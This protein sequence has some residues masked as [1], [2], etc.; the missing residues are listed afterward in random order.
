MSAFHGVF[1]YLVSPIDADGKVMTIQLRQIERIMGNP[2]YILDDTA[3]LS[4]LRGSTPFFYQRLDN[5]IVSNHAKRP[6]W[7]EIVSDKNNTI[8]D[9]F[10]PPLIY[11]IE[12]KL[13]TSLPDAPIE[14]EEVE[15]FGASIVSFDEIP[16]RFRLVSWIGNSPYIEDTKLTKEFGKTTR[17]RLEVN[18]SYSLV[19]NPKPGRPSLTKVDNNS[20]EKL[21]TLKYFSH[22]L[23]LSTLVF[24]QLRDNFFLNNIKYVQHGDL[25]ELV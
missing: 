2:E 1:P 11:L 25:R 12:N 6:E 5:Y 20:S 13:T 19:D 17:N 10:T 23:L 4:V 9:L 21:I 22:L 14:E 3:D 15:A 7:G 8:Y 16:Y 18:N 24:Q